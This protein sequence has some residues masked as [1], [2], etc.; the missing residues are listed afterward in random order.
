MRSRVDSVVAGPCGSACVTL[1][2]AREIE[3]Q[4]DR[5]WRPTWVVFRDRVGSRFRVR[6]CDIRTIVESTTAQR[7]ADRGLDR[8]HRREE[9]ADGHPWDEA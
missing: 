6:A 7:A 8:A 4:L 9:S 1:S 5:R 3:R 2:T